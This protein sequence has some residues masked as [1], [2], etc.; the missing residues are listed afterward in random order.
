[1]AP[2]VQLHNRKHVASAETSTTLSSN[3]SKTIITATTVA[4]AKSAVVLVD[5]LDSS[6]AINGRIKLPPSLSLSSTNT[7]STTSNPRRLSVRLE[8]L[9]QQQ[10]HQLRRRPDN[11]HQ[12]SSNVHDNL[13][14]RQS[15]VQKS[16]K[17][18][19]PGKFSAN[20]KPNFNNSRKRSRILRNAAFSQ[21]MKPSAW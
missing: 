7:T 9:Q 8:N 4:K 2:K 10:Q 3:C 21:S 6:K 11:K 20:G 16:N 17:Q 18:Q 5:R 13:S 12:T 19:L 15:N 1:M 14:R